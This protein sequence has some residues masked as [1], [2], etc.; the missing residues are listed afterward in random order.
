MSRAIY[1][2]TAGTEER[3]SDP[4]SRAAV[5]SAANTANRAIFRGIQIDLNMSSGEE[6]QIL[7]GLKSVLHNLNTKL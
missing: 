4:P 5:L 3:T 7:N 6:I 2:E 1:R